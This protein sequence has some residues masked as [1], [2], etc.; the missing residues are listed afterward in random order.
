LA[1]P[2]ANDSE[3]TRLRHASD[4]HYSGISSPFREEGECDPLYA[5]GIK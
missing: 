1:K 4:A 3:V 2:F 5:F